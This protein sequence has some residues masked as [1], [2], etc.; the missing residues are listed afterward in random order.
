MIDDSFSTDKQKL[1]QREL[2]ELGVPITNLSVQKDNKEKTTEE[3]L[4]ELVDI[5]EETIKFQEEVMKSNK[6]A[7]EKHL[8]LKEILVDRQRE[9]L[10]L[11]E[12]TI[13]LQKTYERVTTIGFWI[14]SA[15]CMFTLIFLT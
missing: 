13:K 12:K 4:Y 14:M 1:I 2:S 6:E 10:G 11:Q 5:Q 3:E 8:A 15:L 7:Y 9:L